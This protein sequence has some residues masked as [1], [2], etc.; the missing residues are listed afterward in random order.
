VSLDGFVVTR[1]RFRGQ[2]ETP[3][4]FSTLHARRWERRTGDTSGPTH[5]RAVR[6]T[7]TRVRRDGRR[8]RRRKAESSRLLTTV[9][10]RPR[11]EA[12][13]PTT[14]ARRETPS[15]RVSAVERAPPLGSRRAPRLQ[16]NYVRISTLITARYIGKECIRV[17]IRRTSAD[18]LAGVG[19]ETLDQGD[20]L[21]A[22]LALTAQALLVARGHVGVQVLL[23]RAP[24]QNL[25]RGEG[26][27]AKRSAAGSGP[28][29]ARG[30]ARVAK[31]REWR[32]GV[33]RTRVRERERPSHDR[34]ERV[35]VPDS[36]ARRM[37]RKNPEP[38]S[39]MAYPRASG[40]RARARREPRM[41]VFPLRT[42]PLAVILNRLAADLLVLALP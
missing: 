38:Y 3:S 22:N 29:R 35:V 19:Q 18:S 10:T 8:T 2:K 33:V 17:R 9:K 37:S 20:L 41:W 27:E 5:D 1:A 31:T 24:V 14:H 26:G 15:P 36:P 16:K 39:A 25:F 30:T 6:S 32:L 42:F 13:T 7:K 28:G 11:N 23:T 21:T 4:F 34:R 12:H 40:R